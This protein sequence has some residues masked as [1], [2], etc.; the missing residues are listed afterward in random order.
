MML[1]KY[2]V[3]IYIILDPYNNYNISIKGT[4]EKR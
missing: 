1:I 2:S 4:A 3:F